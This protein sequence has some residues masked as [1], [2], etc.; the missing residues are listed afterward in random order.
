M[1]SRLEVIDELAKRERRKTIDELAKRERRKT[2]DELAKRER[3][4]RETGAT[5]EG[6]TRLQWAWFQTLG[7]TSGERDC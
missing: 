5:R 2:L 3:R 6:H 4:K 1:Q 7:T